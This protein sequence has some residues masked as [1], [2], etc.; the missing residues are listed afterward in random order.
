MQIVIAWAV[1][2]LVFDD[3]LDWLIG[4]LINCCLAYLP[5]IPMVIPR[6]SLIGNRVHSFLSL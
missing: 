6:I 3:E 5:T 4:C 2:I 1:I